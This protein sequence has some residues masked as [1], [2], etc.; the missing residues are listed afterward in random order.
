[1]CVLLPNTLNTLNHHVGYNIGS[2]AWARRD[3]IETNR[4]RATGGV[5]DVHASGGDKAHTVAMVND[6]REQ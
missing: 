3:G 1:M 5:N 6:G 2:E 4:M